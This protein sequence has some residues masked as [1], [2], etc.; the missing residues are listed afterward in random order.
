MPKLEIGITMTK[1]AIFFF[2]VN[3]VNY[4]S[5]PI[6]SQCFKALAQIGYQDILLKRKSD[7]RMNG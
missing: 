2:K 1:F 5:A 3:Q 4:S 7:D 6:S